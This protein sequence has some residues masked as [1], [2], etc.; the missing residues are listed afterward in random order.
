MD[1]IAAFPRSSRTLG[2]GENMCK[3]SLA[4]TGEQW[5]CRSGRSGAKSRLPD[6]DRLVV[7]DSIPRVWKAPRP[8]AVLVHGLAGN[9]EA[10]YVVRLARRL[11]K[12]G[13]RVIRVNL[14][15][16][17]A[18]FGLARGTYHAG[19]S[20]DLRHVMNW[21][22]ARVEGSPIAL[23][24]YSLGANLVL[25][26]A[27]ESAAHPVP[28]FDCVVAANPPLNLGACSRA[29]ERRRTAFTS[30]TSCDG[31]GAWSSGC[32]TAFRTWR[33]AKLEGVKT[34]YDFDDRY[35]APRNNF[36]SA[37]NYYA[38][39]SLDDAL[40]KIPQPGLI[41]HAQDDPFIPADV[42]VRAVR[43]QHLALELSAGGGHLGYLSRER[44]LGDHRWLETRLCAWLLAHSA[45]GEGSPQHDL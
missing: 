23:V 2:S 24:G 19:S 37:V 36:G 1:F 14:R 38:T 33:P 40:L 31:C 8:A 3:R 6:G 20:D 16:A 22:A 27:A 11:L 18:G 13:I 43:P 29:I 4:D 12:N 42:I 39:C 32:M 34:L 7:F 26:L 25:K 21:A 30:G 45:L 5:R 44:W 15:G 17:G 28:N 10:P 35:T 9:S 41:V